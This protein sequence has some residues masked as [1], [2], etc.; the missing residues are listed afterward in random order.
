MR[1]IFVPRVDPRDMPPSIHNSSINNVPQSA[2]P[3]KAGQH[4]GDAEKEES[5]GAQ[6]IA[7]E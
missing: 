7:E 4:E 3:V 5:G 1:G 6:V 2:K